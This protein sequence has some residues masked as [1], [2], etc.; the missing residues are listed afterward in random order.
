[1]NDRLKELAV[2]A[3]KLAKEESKDGDNACRVGSDYFLAMERAKFAELIVQE[4]SNFVY[5]YPEKYL[6]R[7]QAKEMCLSMEHNFGVEK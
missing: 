2:Q 6:T 1:M 7:D 4:C 5:N 3:H